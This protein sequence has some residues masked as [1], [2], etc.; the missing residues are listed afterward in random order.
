MR[1]QRVTGGGGEGGSA[2]R[3]KEYLQKKC[4][5]CAFVSD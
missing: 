4:K 2:S 5:Y 1:E 3:K